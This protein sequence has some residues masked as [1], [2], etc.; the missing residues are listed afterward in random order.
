MKKIIRIIKDNYLVITFIILLPII[1]SSLLEVISSCGIDPILFIILFFFIIFPYGYWYGYKCGSPGKR[2]LSKKKNFLMKLILI[3][4]PLL[5][6]LILNLLWSCNI[7]QI[8][9]SICIFGLNPFMSYWVGYY[10]I[11][12]KRERIRS[13]H[14]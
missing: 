12:R 13:G 1:I 10:V 8:L 9:L 5:L 14:C 6:I 2:F 4:I 7:S 11:S 3:T